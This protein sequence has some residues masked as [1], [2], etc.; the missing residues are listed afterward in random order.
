MLGGAIG[1]G[2]EQMIPANFGVILTDI[3]DQAA[4]WRERNIRVHVL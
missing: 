3:G 2:D 4:V 1:V